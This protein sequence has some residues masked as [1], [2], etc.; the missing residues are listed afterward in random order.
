MIKNLQQGKCSAKSAIH[1]IF[2][3][4][5]KSELADP[6]P[7]SPT[8]KKKSGGPMGILAARPEWRIVIKVKFL[9]YQGLH[10]SIDNKEKIYR[11]NYFSQS[12]SISH[13][14]QIIVNK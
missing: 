9:G 1:S 13:V 4:V 3:L 12:D 8:Q 11:C 2:I 14:I 6:D 10:N 5:Q 7:G